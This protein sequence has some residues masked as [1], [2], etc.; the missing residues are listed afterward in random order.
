[1][2]LRAQ[3]P[4]DEVRDAPLVLDQK[5]P[6]PAIVR[7]ARARPVRELSRDP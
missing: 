1:V 6:H 5:D 7:A 3:R 4:L 2:A